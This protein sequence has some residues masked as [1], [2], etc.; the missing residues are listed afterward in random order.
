MYILLTL[1]NFKTVIKTTDL[2][3]KYI[4]TERKL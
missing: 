1:F 3:F 2:L 4:S